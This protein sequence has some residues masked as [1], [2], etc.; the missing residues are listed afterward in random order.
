MQI[1]S[2]GADELSTGRYFSLSL[3]P[4]IIVREKAIGNLGERYL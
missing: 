4:G 1:V 3:S 2:I